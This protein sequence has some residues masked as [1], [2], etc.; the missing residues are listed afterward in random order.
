M[1]LNWRQV[2]NNYNR[3]IERLNN[4]KKFPLVG[5][6]KP[7]PTPVKRRVL[8][9]IKQ[10]YILN[11]NEIQ[12]LRE[13]A[14]RKQKE[15]PPPK[16]MTPV[17]RNSPKP[18]KQNYILNKNEIQ[19]LKEAAKK[20]E[21]NKILNAL[22][23]N[24]NFS[25]EKMNKLSQNTKNKLQKYITFQLSKSNWTNNHYK[26]EKALLGVFNEKKEFLKKGLGLKRFEGPMKTAFR[27]PIRKYKKV[28]P[29]IEQGRKGLSLSINTTEGQ[30]EYGKKYHIHLQDFKIGSQIGA[31]SLYGKV[32]KLR[33]KNGNDDKYVL[34]RIQFRDDYSRQSFENEVR[35]GQ[36]PGIEQVGPRI[37]AY[38]FVTNDNA[39]IKFGEYIMDNITHGETYTRVEDLNDY[40]KRLYGTW[41][42]PYSKGNYPI[43]KPFRETLVKFYKI[44]KGF[45]GD[46]HGGN[47]FVLTKPDG[48][49][50]V[51]FIDFGAHREFKNNKN[52]DCIEKYF[53]K[54][55]KQVG[56]NVS[57]YHGKQPGRFFEF[58][59]GQLFT[60]NEH[61]L[62]N[63]GLLGKL[64][65]INEKPRTNRQK[66]LDNFFSPKVVR[67]LEKI[68]SNRTTIYRPSR[69]FHLGLL[70]KQRQKNKNTVL[71]E[72]NI[73]NYNKFNNSI[74]YFN[75]RP[76][77]VYNKKRFTNSL[78]NQ[79]LRVHIL[80][81]LENYNRNTKS[82]Y[83]N[84]RTKKFNQSKLNKALD[85]KKIKN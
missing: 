82:W 84:R 64:K 66:Q 25:K 56:T 65:D 51:R 61:R 5:N 72:N 27:K 14:M 7:L 21:T 39:G 57:F 12:Q 47:V 15:R 19:Q 31:N 70:I 32:F 40:F 18:I 11:K 54:E 20:R 29:Y 42:C 13:A 26:L 85:L 78:R 60:S 73:K 48:E 28:T 6:V 76:S 62:A 2:T 34:K 74:K 41:F 77:E 17:K 23:K 10:N 69:P 55:F 33:D 63:Y 67:E 38:R 30:T 58:N 59:N 49:I 79:P 71:S 24:K 53:Q 75:N 68:M 43:V 9:P 52:V 83:V 46:L 45:H 81:A 22:M 3:E 1:A 4:N 35:V 37:Y 8:P 50:K 36:L 16:P 80:R 44:T